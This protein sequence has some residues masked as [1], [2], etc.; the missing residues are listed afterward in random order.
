MSPIRTMKVTRM[1]MSRGMTRKKAVRRF[2]RSA[3]A[4]LTLSGSPEAV[5]MAPEV[6]TASA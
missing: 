4:R 6:V 2:F 5:I 1:K 3:R